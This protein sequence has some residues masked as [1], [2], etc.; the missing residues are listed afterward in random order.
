MIS[1]AIENHFCAIISSIAYNKWATMTKF[2]SVL[3]D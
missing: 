3:V 1:V 2:V